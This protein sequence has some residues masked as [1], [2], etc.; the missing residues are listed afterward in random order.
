[1]SSSTSKHIHLF[2]LPLTLPMC[3]CFSPPSCV[4]LFP[5]DRVAAYCSEGC[6]EVSWEMGHMSHC[7]QVD[8]FRGAPIATKGVMTSTATKT[9]PSTPSSTA[10][11][12]PA[13]LVLKLKTGADL[14]QMS[15]AHETILSGQGSVIFLTLSLTHSL[16]LSFGSVL[17]DS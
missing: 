11:H 4:L 3:S 15:E 1:V 10:C 14:T 13:T 2:L 6:L 12:H 17:V 9:L 5:F 7:K 8:Q 16:T